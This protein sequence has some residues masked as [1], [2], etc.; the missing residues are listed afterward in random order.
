MAAVNNLVTQFSFVG[1]L[2]PQETFNQNLGVSIGLIAG[3]STAIVGATGAFIAWTTSVTEAIDPMVQ[4]SR[5]TDVSV[6]AIQELGYAASQN[7]SD[8]DAVM[9]S[10]KELTKRSGEFARTGGGSAAEAFLQLG[11]SVRGANGQMKTA[12]RLMMDV[13][14]SMQ[15]YS[16][17][18]QA[19]LLDKLGIDPSMI[20]LMN[21]S[22]DAIDA[23]RMKAQA[24]G[25]I[26]KEQADA[27]AS[28][29]DSNTTL[30][31]GLQ[32]L[33]NQIAT[34]MAPVLQSITEDFIDF[35]MANKDLIQNGIKA[36]GKGLIALTGFIKRMT[37]VVLIA[38]AAF[39]AW[40]IANFGVAASLALIFSP[41]VLITAGIIGMALVIDDLIVAF[42]GGNS[43]IA[44][45]I[46]NMTA[47]EVVPYIV[48]GIAA[49]FVVWQVA[50][51]GVV[52]TMAA[53]FSPVVL[54]AAAVALAVLAVNDLV[55]AFFGGNSVI[56][57]FI[58]QWTGFDIV[59]MLHD[60]VDGITDFAS[61]AYD[62]FIQVR[63][64]IFGIFRGVGQVW[65]GDFTAGFSTLYDVAAGVIDMITELFTGSF[66]FISE[67]LSSLAPDFL[68]DWMG[69]DE[70]TDGFRG[71]NNGAVNNGVSNQSNQT[72][73]INQ[74]SNAN[75]YTT[76]SEAAGKSVYNYQ[77]QQHKETKQYYSRGGM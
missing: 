11:V 71:G 67:Q 8:V 43:V 42:N 58:K 69:D 9:S 30:K 14:R 70:P 27:A 4:L 5:E 20:Q 38:A 63:D 28:L 32:G 73:N 57:D 46:K 26:T 16:K 51:A 22:G 40:Q 34:G 44:N 64:L 21:Q 36:L 29:N 10:I 50:T 31:F 52:A 13:S 62:K 45:F 7:G 75:V 48:L 18:E 12:D 53:L 24:L 1:S 41:I 6:G 77:A 25:T 33:Q 2:R 66:D 55:A 56:A 15:S 61:F 39:G 76:D 35:L 49:A 17:S 19:D 54:I 68:K 3:A 72:V 65:E 37:P 23:L 47:F 59:P 74:S 60:A